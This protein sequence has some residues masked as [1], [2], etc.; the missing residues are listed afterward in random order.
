M[1]CNPIELMEHKE[2]KKIRASEFIVRDIHSKVPIYMS[3]W[4]GT[5]KEGARHRRS[6]RLHRKISMVVGKVSIWTALVFQHGSGY[7]ILQR[8]Q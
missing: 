4:D 3:L 2:D 5:V 1:G 6:N 7:R 8:K